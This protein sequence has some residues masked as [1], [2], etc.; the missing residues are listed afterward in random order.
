MVKEHA[1]PKLQFLNVKKVEGH[2]SLV[3]WYKMNFAVEELQEIFF[4][5]WLSL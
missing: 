3:A 1:L 2:C 5:H 4:G